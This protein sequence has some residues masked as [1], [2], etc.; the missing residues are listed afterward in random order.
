MLQE[1]TT[2][3]SARDAAV[4]TQ[5]P[6]TDRKEELEKL[7]FLELYTRLVGVDPEMAEKL[8]PHDKRKVARLA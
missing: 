8:H 7:D 5:T 6:V 2:V 4:V 1:G 3:C